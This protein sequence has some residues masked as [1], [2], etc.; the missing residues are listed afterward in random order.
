MMPS[1][2]IDVECTECG[3]VMGYMDIDASGLHGDPT[4]VEN[5]AVKW[6][7]HYQ[8]G[9]IEFTCQDCTSS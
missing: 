7:G 6:G 5:G 2:M 1:Q 4:Y 9:V 8:S 3:E